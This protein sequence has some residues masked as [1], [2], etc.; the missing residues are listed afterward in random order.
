M[1]FQGADVMIV[2]ICYGGLETETV[3]ATQML[4]EYSKWFAPSDDKRLPVNNIEWRLIPNPSVAVARNQAVDE[5]LVSKAKSLLMIDRDH[6]FNCA[7]LKILFEVD[8]E[9]ITALYTTAI[10]SFKD[11]GNTLIEPVALREFEG[12]VN[13]L[14]QPEINRHFEKY[15]AE[16]MEVD[17]SGLGLTLIK[18]KVFETIPKPWFAQPEHLGSPQCVCG[19][20]YYFCKKRESMDLRLGFILYVQ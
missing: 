15:P 10:K 14:T 17:F 3:Q 1:K 4:Y 20:D 11:S 2:S 7:Y 9:I 5:F 19:E 13:S 8:K 16:P 6:I 18:R 12:K